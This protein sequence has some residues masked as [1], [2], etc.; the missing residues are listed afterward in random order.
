[1]KI[2]PVSFLKGEVILPG[3]KSVSHRSAILASMAD[4]TTRID[5]FSASADCASTLECLRGLG[6]SIERDGSHVKV[7]GV[8]KTGFVRPDA[9]LDCGNSGT[10]MRLLSGVLAGQQFDSILTGDDSLRNRPMRRVITPL[11]RMGAVIDAADGT[12]P[13]FIRGRNPL[14]SATIVPEVASAQ[15]KSAILLAGLNSDGITSV[16]ESTPTR[17]HTERMLRWLGTDVSEEVFETYKKVSVS[18]DSDLSAR[19]IVVP[20]DI[21]AAVFFMVAA[22]CLPGSEVWMKGVG[23]NG[24]RRAIIEVLRGF[25]A[26]IEISDERDVCNEPVADIRVKGGLRH[27]TASSDR[28]EGDLIAG[29]IDEIPALAVFGTQLDSGLVV[30]DAAELRVKESDRIKTV[31]EN[32]RRMGADVEEFDDGF[33]VRRSQ[34]KGAKI[35]PAGDHRIAMAFA[36]AGLFAEG[37]TQ[38]EEAECCEVSFPG[39]FDVLGGVSRPSTGN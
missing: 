4:G 28:V 39:F 15:I 35:Y 11:A 3:D 27:G 18:G 29:I 16:I 32:L 22:S 34:L 19:D 6:V 37:P 2:E 8:G 20:S 23:V 7:N 25:G 36:V 13:L 14:R 10:T 26:D 31:V 5:N 17:D 33:A 38:I 24:S 21:S 30:R 9:P 1:M 12:A